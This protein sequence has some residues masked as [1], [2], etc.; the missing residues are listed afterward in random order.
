MGEAVRVSY[1]CGHP[2]TPENT[3]TVGGR[4]EYCRI[5]NRQAANRRYRARNPGAKQKA[6]LSLDDKFAA[7]LKKTPDHW[8]WQG[9][10][11]DGSVAIC[12]FGGKAV[13]VAQ[14]LWKR[15][16]GA[17]AHRQCLYRTCDI[18]RCVR[19]GC[20]VAQVRASHITSAIRG[21][22]GKP[23]KGPKRIYGL[24]PEFAALIG[25]ID[26]DQYLA[27]YRRLH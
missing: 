10:M 16:H 20:R 5:C 18:A 15:E 4:Y 21:I 7:L 8:I 25:L 22:R 3:V 13:F 24:S 14:E 19:P 17:V 26:V 2:K 23:R 11:R 6:F 9:D 27:C 1:A 12:H